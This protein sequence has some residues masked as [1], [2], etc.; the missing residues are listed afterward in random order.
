[1]EHPQMIGV[2]RTVSVH[3]RFWDNLSD[4]L[5]APFP[6]YLNDDRKNIAL[7]F[8]VSVFVTG[9]LYVFKTQSENQFSQGL[10]WLHGVITF[11][12]LLF[13]IVLLPKLFPVAMDAVSWTFSKYLLLNFGHLVL[14]WVACTLIEKP[15]FCPDL[16]W[17]TVATHVGTQ[18]ALKGIIPIALTTLFLKA[19]LLQQNLQEAISTNQELQKIQTLKKEVRQVKGKTFACIRV[20]CNSVIRLWGILFKGLNFLQLLI[21]ADRFL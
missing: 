13:N 2:E 14:I 16:A 7:V 19:H 8:A 20:K 21:G 9:F 18:V 10:E 15:L 11:G 1:M 17:L 6:F 5:K 4:S 3:K 12:C